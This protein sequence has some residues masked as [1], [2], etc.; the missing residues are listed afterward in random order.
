[1]ATTDITICN[2]ALIKLGSDIIETFNEPFESK[3]AQL[4][5]LQFEKIRDLLLYSHPWNFATKRA[6]IDTN[7]NDSEWGGLKEFDLPL[8]YLRVIDLNGEVHPE[9]PW[10]IEGDKLY[11]D[12]DTLEF[13]YIARVTDPELFSAGFRELLALAI[14]NELSYSLVQS[15]TIKETIQREYMTQLSDLRS[16]DSQEGTTLQVTNHRYLGVRK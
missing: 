4:C 2:S 10:Y 8:D 16:F 9:T 1:M 3:E 11:S 15:A 14:A 7:G 12:D 5:K 6:K 13:K